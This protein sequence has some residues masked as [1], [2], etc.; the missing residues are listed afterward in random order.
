MTRYDLGEL[1]IHTS[2]GIET[3][4]QFV[5]LTYVLHLTSNGGYCGKISNRSNK[6][7]LSR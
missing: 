2:Y 6:K 4:K 7:I 1:S 5:P 3:I